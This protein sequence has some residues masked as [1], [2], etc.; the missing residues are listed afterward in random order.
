[1]TNNNI[2]NVQQKHDQW[3]TPLGWDNMCLSL[4][5]AYRSAPT[6][7]HI[8]SSNT[9]S[10]SARLYKHALDGSECWAV[11]KRDVDKIDVL[12][13]WCLQKLLGIEWY[14]SE[15]WCKTDNRATTPFGYCTS[16]QF[17]PVRPQCINARSNRCQEYP[18]SFPLWRTGGDHWDT[19]LLCG[20]RYPSGPEIQ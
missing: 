2:N 10:W 14:H 13:Q 17:L 6:E 5:T 7:A 8:C 15:W 3:I 12:D 19:L 1:M 9:S 11:I 4:A 20:W 18:N 16:T